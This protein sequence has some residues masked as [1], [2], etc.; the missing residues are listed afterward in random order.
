MY[1]DVTEID[2]DFSEELE[3]NLNSDLGKI[4]DYFNVSR[5]SLYAHKYDYIVI[6]TYKSLAKMPKMSIHINNDDEPLHKVTFSKYIEM[7]I[8]TNLT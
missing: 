7:L 1:E 2:S 5:L 6:G 3:S 4:K 8:D